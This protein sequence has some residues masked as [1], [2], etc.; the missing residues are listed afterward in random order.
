MQTRPDASGHDLAI[1][2]AD[3][4]AS[5][6]DRPVE[7]MVIDGNRDGR[8]VLFA[9]DE[10]VA[11]LEEHPGMLDGSLQRRSPDIHDKRVCA[12]CHHQS[13]PYSRNSAC[14]ECHGDMY[15]ETDIFGHSAHV[16]KL[17]G[18]DGCSRCHEDSHLAK[19]RSTTKACLDCHEEMVAV[20]SRI[21]RPEA[22][23]TGYAVGYM[24]A[25]HDLCIGCHEEKVEKE[26]ATYGEE[27]STCKNCHRDVD[28][29]QL[30]QMAPYLPKGTVA[31][32]GRLGRERMALSFAGMAA[33]PPR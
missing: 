7:L 27:F 28:G 8:I 29:S 18:N 30:R 20:G 3:Y 26:P 21:E 25:M 22:G 9:H 6:E 1:V 15:I 32:P 13:L 24:D 16:A 11:E 14:S 10:H 33:G 23:M 31:R 5:A 2:E 4:P 17:D 12:T 19:T